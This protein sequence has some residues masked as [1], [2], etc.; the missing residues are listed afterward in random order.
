MD[1]YCEITIY[2]SKESANIRE[3]NSNIFSKIFAYNIFAKLLILLNLN[4]TNYYYLLEIL[5][6]IF[7]N[8]ILFYK[9]LPWTYDTKIAQIQMKRGW[10]NRLNK[11]NKKNRSEGVV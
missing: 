4:E 10:R 11:Y 8:C 2:Y 3:R 9:I 5:L 7:F 6:L 1:D